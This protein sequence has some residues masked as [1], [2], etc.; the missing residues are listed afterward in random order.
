MKE[1]ITI[2]LGNLGDITATKDAFNELSITF[3][4]AKKQYEMEECF[5]LAKKAEKISTTIHSE[6]EKIGYYNK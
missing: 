3:Y 5:G 1:R 4:Y 2:T 6:L